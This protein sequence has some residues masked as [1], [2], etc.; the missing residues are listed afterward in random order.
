MW[1]ACDS[2]G[3]NYGSTRTLALLSFSS[4]HSLFVRSFRADGLGVKGQI[5]TAGLNRTHWP[6]DVKP[7][8]RLWTLWSL[9]LKQSMDNVISFYLTHR[10]K[11]LTLKGY[12]QYWCTFKDT[13][14]SCY[15]SK[16]ESSGTPAHQMNLRG[17]PWDDHC[18]WWNI[19]E[20]IFN[21]L[22]FAGRKSFS[23]V[24]ALLTYFYISSSTL[25]IVPSSPLTWLE[26]WFRWK[27]TFL[28]R[29]AGCF[30]SWRTPACRMLWLL[31]RASC[32]LLDSWWATLTVMLFPKASWL[33]SSS[34]TTS[35]RK[36]YPW[37]PLR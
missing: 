7:G 21:I 12:K 36:L 18:W 10:P 28:S 15:K 14:I 34:D 30:C 29:F 3:Y 6:A 8:L 24:S 20:L 37:E 35:S 16:E 19:Y 9:V 27:E 4:A 32:S 33:T 22:H 13:S 23:A 25:S 31:C 5:R 11:K 26:R 2:G 1:P 17:K